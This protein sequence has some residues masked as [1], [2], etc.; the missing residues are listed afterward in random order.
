MMRVLHAEHEFSDR[1]IS[2]MLARNI[3]VE[4]H[5][6]DQYFNSIRSGLARAL[7]LAR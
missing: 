6:I 2:Y 3:R 7:L 5:L 1:F 4:A